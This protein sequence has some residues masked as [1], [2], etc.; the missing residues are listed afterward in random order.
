MSASVVTESAKQARSGRADTL[1]GLGVI[2]AGTVLLI[3]ARGIDAAPR[4]GAAG[5]GPAT[6]PLAIAALL[7]VGG[8][9]L[10]FIGARVWRS[11]EPSTSTSS[12]SSIERQ[13]QDLVGESE[14]PVPINKLVIM[15]LLFVGY[16][17]VFIPLGYVLST[18]L[19]L[20][21]V[22]TVIDRAKWK[23]N[24]LFAIGFAVIVYLGFT[25]LL[26]VQLP[27]GLLGLPVGG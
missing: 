25:Q 15:V 16:T 13:V 7:I 17:I 22:T 9:A 2:A 4:S 6:M 14:P 10:T 3:S 11:P 8:V 18:C 26:S 20:G 19:Y 12:D 1:C 5:I 24:T 23:R 21:V 27:A